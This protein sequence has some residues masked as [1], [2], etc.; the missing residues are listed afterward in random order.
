MALLCLVRQRSRHL[1]S[2]YFWALLSRPFNWGSVLFSGALIFQTVSCTP[3][4]EYP[5]DE[6]LQ[7][8][9]GLTFEDRVY[10]VALTGGAAEHADPVV[11][12]IK[13]GAFVEFITADG[14]IHEVIFYE[15]SL[16]SDQ[17]SFLEKTDQTASPPL[18]E[19][20][21]RYI[22]AFEG[23]PL[24]RYPYQIEGNGNPGRGVIVLLEPDDQQ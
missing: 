16:S 10:R 8:E 21:S 17:W 3:E 12:S 2:G 23:A 9:L 20:E 11:L 14:F 24:G 4:N 7:A 1:K 19:L 15:D 6:L 13:Q 5:P 22:L 18:I